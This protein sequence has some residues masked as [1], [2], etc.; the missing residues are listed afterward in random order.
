MFEQLC[1]QW[2][3]FME[4][5]TAFMDG[6]FV[7]KATLEAEQ[8]KVIDLTEKFKA[9]NESGMAATAAAME[10]NKA[11]DAA[12]ISLKT[13]TEKATALETENAKLKADAKTVDEAAS[14]KAQEICKAQGISVANLPKATE[15]KPG[16]KEQEL[17]R[18]RAQMLTEKDPQKKYDLG[19]KC[20]ELRGHA[21]I[22]KK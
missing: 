9:S 1:S 22:F 4:R 13:A 12:E 20:R 14:L 3:A 21:D 11:K 8:A 10:A 15:E 16:S 19:V 18:L 2:K 7:P 5:F 6:A 17:D